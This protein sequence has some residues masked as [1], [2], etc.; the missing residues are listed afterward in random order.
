MFKKCK[1]DTRGTIIPNTATAIAPA[2]E[3]K[4]ATFRSAERSLL[5]KFNGNFA[6]SFTSN[7]SVGLQFTRITRILLRPMLCA[8]CQVT[9]HPCVSDATVEQLKESFVRSPRKSTRRV[10]LETGIPNVTVWRVLR[11]RLH[12]KGCS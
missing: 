3:I 6:L 10:S 2:V 9:H 5:Q 12:L 11:K 7:L 4:M 1:F 8:P